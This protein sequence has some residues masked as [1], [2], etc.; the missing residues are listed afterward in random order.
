MRDETEF[1]EDEGQYDGGILELIGED[2]VPPAV[3]EAMSFGTSED[4]HVE[5]LDKLERIEELLVS[6]S[7]RK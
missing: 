3:D 2:D 1:D 6:L 4:R 7:K 5:L